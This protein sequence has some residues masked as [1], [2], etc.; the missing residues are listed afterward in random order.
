MRFGAAISGGTERHMARRLLIGTMGGMGRAHSNQASANQQAQAARQQQLN[1]YNR[2]QA[3][4]LQG[5]G[6]TVQ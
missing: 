3:A 2:A 1:T 4:C 6:Y 5:R